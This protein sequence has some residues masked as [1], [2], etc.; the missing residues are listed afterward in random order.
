MSRTDSRAKVRS[1]KSS[2]RAERGHP[3]RPLNILRYIVLGLGALVFLFP[4]YYMVV[5]SLQLDPDTTL[6]GAFP[7]PGN[8]TLDNYAAINERIGS[9]TGLASGSSSPWA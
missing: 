3:G 7:H 9:R 5:G 6:A 4:F 1:Q 2:D 8:I